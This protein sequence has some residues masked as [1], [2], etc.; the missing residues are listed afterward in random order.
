MSGYLFTSYRVPTTRKQSLVSLR[1]R[2]PFIRLHSTLELKA[3]THSQ[4]PIIVLTLS[5]VDRRSSL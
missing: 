5:Q 2:F 1:V 3:S 4:N